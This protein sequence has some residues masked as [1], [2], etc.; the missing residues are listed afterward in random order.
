MET[1]ENK[2]NYTTHPKRERGEQYKPYGKPQHTIPKKP[3]KRG[4]Y[5]YA[6]MINPNNIAIGLKNP[7]DEAF[8]SLQQRDDGY[9]CPF[10][11]N[12]FHSKEE[13][14]NH[15]HADHEYE[16]EVINNG[17]RNENEGIMMNVIDA[18]NKGYNSNTGV[19]E[20]IYDGKAFTSNDQEKNFS[21]L[22]NHIKSN[23]A[24]IFKEQPPT[25][26]P[27]GSITRTNPG[28]KNH[29]LEFYIRQPRRAT[30]HKYSGKPREMKRR[31]R[32]DANQ[33][34]GDVSRTPP[35]YGLKNGD[36]VAH[37]IAFKYADMLK[38]FGF[39]RLTQIDDYFCKKLEHE[40]DRYLRNLEVLFSVYRDGIYSAQISKGR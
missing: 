23:H 31:K 40:Y 13:F 17:I 26:L 11:G 8:A 19:A 2:Q 30:S 14:I 28:T 36:V 5:P 29:N 24:D 20:C 9:H 37:L 35:I 12:I 22:I 10:E 4:K 27:Q 25:L 3:Y 7:V 15:L 18:A 1:E 34:N 33:M 21:D 16:M 6:P 39:T 32:F 38:G